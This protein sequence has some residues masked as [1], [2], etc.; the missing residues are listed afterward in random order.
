MIINSKPSTAEYIAEFTTA[1]RS[2]TKLSE[3][4]GV[5][6]VISE[7]VSVVFGYFVSPVVRPG[8]LFSRSYV[9][10]HVTTCPFK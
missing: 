9:V 5:Y 7:Y 10:Y 8:S 1:K 6:T 2:L 4:L 3:V